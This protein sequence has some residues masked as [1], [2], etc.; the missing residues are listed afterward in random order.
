MR[1]KNACRAHFCVACTYA[2]SVVV[3]IHDAVLD[4]SDYGGVVFKQHDAEHLRVERR[5][6]RQTCGGKKKESSCG[7]K[8]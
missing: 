5:R 8:H 4:V 3:L 6:R 1:T 7:V 2:D